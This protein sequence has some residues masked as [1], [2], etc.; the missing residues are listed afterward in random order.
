MLKLRARRGAVAV[1]TVLL[2]LALMGIGAV[3]VDFARL[4]LMR[5]QLQ[6]AADAAAL[7]GALQLT[8][9]N[10]YDY[11]SQAKT[12]GQANPLFDEQV[13]VPDDA[14]EVGRWDRDART[15]TATGSPPTADAVRVTLRHQ[16]SYL[17]GNIL[18][19]APKPVVAR[20]VAWAGPSVSKTTCMKPWALWLGQLMEKINLHETGST[21]DPNRPM[22]ADD[23]LALRDMTPEEL[24]FTV[25]MGNAGP[26]PDW[27]GN[28][29]AVDLPPFYHA[30][31]TTPGDAAPGAQEYENN[32]NGETCNSVNI[33]DSLY[34]E[35][36]GMVGKT[37][38]GVVGSESCKLD[39][40]QPRVCDSMDG[41]NNCL[42]PDGQPI[43]VKTA[44]WTIPPTENGTGK[45]PVAVAMIGSFKLE[46]FF[47]TTGQGG[48]KAQLTGVFQPEAD[49][50]PIGSQTT[51]LVKIVLVQ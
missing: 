37:C 27:S 12:I 38:A 9:A 4:E 43:V 11:L 22:T 26:D 51:T 14:V 30:D 7:A 17:M 42:G 21:G 10:K 29:Y 15:F 39:P 48:Q 18:G 40:S 6:T 36:G 19:F 13:V 3:V 1:L 33:G 44:F 5:N 49:P 41:S 23:L 45:F 34:T 35:T 32:I 16:S 20:A 24:R 25:F 8:R 2:F 31:G 50:G 28:F 47:V 46:K